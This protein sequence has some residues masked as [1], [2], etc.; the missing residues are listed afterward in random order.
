[1]AKTEK[2]VSKFKKT[3][4]AQRILFSKFGKSLS[5]YMI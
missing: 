3:G 5:E 2:E 4:S 1:L